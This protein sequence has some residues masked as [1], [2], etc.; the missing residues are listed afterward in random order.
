MGK[1]LHANPAEE[2]DLLIAISNWLY[3][4]LCRSEKK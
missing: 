4:I 3:I 2:D 1:K